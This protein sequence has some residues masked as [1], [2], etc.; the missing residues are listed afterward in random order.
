M[1]TP[2]RIHGR[3]GLIAEV[4]ESGELVTAPKAYSDSVFLALTSINTAYNFYTPE[5]HK[6]FVITGFNIKADRG[7]STTVAAEVIMYEADTVDSTTVVKTLFQDA[8]VRGERTGLTNT[9]ILVNVGKWVSIKTTDN[10][11]YAT[12]FGYYI[13]EIK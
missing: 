12:I 5:P 3:N 11:I 13:N 4:T 2:V 10:N 1:A 9:N 7:V 8:M 6:Q